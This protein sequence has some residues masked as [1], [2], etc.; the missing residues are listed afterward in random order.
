MILSTTASLCS[1]CLI[2][3]YYL[4]LLYPV[5]DNYLYADNG[6]DPHTFSKKIAVL[7]RILWAKYQ[8]WLIEC[9][10]VLHT[11]ITCGHFIMYMWP[12]VSARSMPGSL[13]VTP[14][15]LYVPYSAY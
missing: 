9:Y 11:D 13:R 4:L 8:K 5:F 2:C 12:F 15:I 3:L 7:L 10:T 6:M 1:I 14:T